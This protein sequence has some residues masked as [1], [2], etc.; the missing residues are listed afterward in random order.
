MGKDKLRRFQELHTFPNVIESG[1]DE[2]F[3]AD[4][5]VKGKWSTTHFGNS[6]PI[7]LELGCGKGEYTVN[8]AEKYPEKNFIGIDIKGNRM[9]VGAKQALE[10]KLTNVMFLRTRIE[11]I[12]S[13]FIADEVDEIWIT[14]PDPQET[15]SRRRKRLTS[16]V[17]LN[18]YKS[19]LKNDGILHLKTDND[20]L[21]DYTTRLV[22]L[23]DL[24]LLIHT[25][26]LYNSEYADLTHSIKTHY[27][28]LFLNEGK[29]I[30]Y[31]QFSIHGNKDLNEP[32]ES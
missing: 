15:K 22:K 18:K 6:N 28:Q 12:R 32:E 20:T 13:F 19:F 25:F 17:F 1:I 9:W 27:E 23:N 26:D 7:V 30:H 16:T 5:P 11:F 31:M 2:V 29:P 8:L 14:F 10:K 4:H 24:K 3:T 21:F